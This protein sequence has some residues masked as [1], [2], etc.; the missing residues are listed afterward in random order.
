MNVGGVPIVSKSCL[1]HN[2]FAALEPLSFG[3]GITETQKIFH[4]MPNAACTC[5]YYISRKN[6]D[7]ML[8][9]GEIYVLLRV[10][11]AGF[12]A[13]EWREAVAAHKRPWTN[14]K[15]I[16]N[17]DTVR[18]YVDGNG[19]GHYERSRIEQYAE[20]VNKTFQS[21][22]AALVPVCDVCGLK[23]IS[24]LRQFDFVRE[25]APGARLGH[26]D[27]LQMIPR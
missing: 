12:F 23:D 1:L 13:P 26:R 5:H 14:A 7:A 17:R 2:C 20:S 9:R 21:L 19:A 11:S 25:Q 4:P 16:S 15:T 24:T 8:G 22:G 10:T 27:C 3:H 18:A 6:R